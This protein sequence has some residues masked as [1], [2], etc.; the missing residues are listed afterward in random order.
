MPNRDFIDRDLYAPRDEIPR[1]KM[2]PGDEPPPPHVE[3]LGPDAARSVS[4]LNLPLMVR[5]RQALDQQAAASARQME[6]LRLLQEQLEREK[7]EIEEA[8]RAQDDFITGRKELT[9]RL[10][11]S[12]VAIERHEARATQLAELL[13][14]TRQRFR[15]MLDELSMIREDEWAEQEIRDRVRESL[16]R[17]DDIRMEFNKAMARVE[18]AMGTDARPADSASMR[19]ES[20]P[21]AATAER[22]LGRWFVIGLMVSLPGIVTAVLITALLWFRAHAF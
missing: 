22:T 11:Q 6:E 10:T 7:R 17:M 15:A 16:A 4:D 18:A 21:T 19:I 14:A 9:D 3:T 5:Q 8:R 13:Q 12:L 20:H 2:G 1:V